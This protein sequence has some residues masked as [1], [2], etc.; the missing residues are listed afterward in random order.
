[1]STIVPA[2]L[3][4]MPLNF[5]LYTK[6]SGGDI[7]PFIRVGEELKHRGHQVILMTHCGYEARAKGSDLDF[8]ALDSPQEYASFLAD[9]ELLNSPQGIAH[10]LMR[11]SLSRAPG[12]YQLV[13][14]QCKGNNSI[15]VTRDLFDLVPRLAGEKLRLP[16]RWMFGN[17]SQ[18]ATWELREQLFSQF[19]GSEIDRVRITLGLPSAPV[20]SGEFGASSL[21]VALWPEWFAASNANYPI[22]VAPV[23]FIREDDAPGVDVPPIIERVLN[24]GKP[25]VLITA[26]TGMYLGSNFYDVTAKACELVDCAGI[27]VTQHSAQLPEDCRSCVSWV[28]ILPFRRLMQQVH[29][30]IHH[31]GLGTLACA[32][33]AGIPQLVLPKGADRPD[34]AARLQNL[35]VAEFLP[36]PKWQPQLIA[37]ALMRLLSSPRVAEK[38]RTFAD[39]L[40]DHDGTQAACQAIEQ[41]SPP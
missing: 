1:M 15:I 33:A 29:V 25:T 31:G 38:C 16:L 4:D 40:K 34:N 36:P 37:Q 14:Q 18:V 28:G 21:G 11:H 22:P 5:V 35:G 3:P 10:F 19:L 12:E 41:L 23:G 9:Q 20:A 7:F 24:C 17:P 27:A 39:R 8:V 32:M 26:G 6:G 13:S 30:V 2:P